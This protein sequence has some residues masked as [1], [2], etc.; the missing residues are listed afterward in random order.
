L[1]G[2]KG[3][4][5][6][7]QDGLLNRFPFKC[8]VVLEADRTGKVLWEVRHPGHHYRGI[9][10]HYRGILLCNGNVLLNCMGQ[11]P[12]DIARRVRSVTPC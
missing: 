9:L 2:F 10:L 12:D 7:S 1:P 5:R 3:N 11:V 8:G 6:T 4:R